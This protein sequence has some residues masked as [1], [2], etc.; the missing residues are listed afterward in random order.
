MRTNSPAFR[1]TER[2]LA[3]GM[4]DNGRL[5]RSDRLAMRLARHT[6]TALARARFLAKTAWYNG[7][8]TPESAVKHVF[9]WDWVSPWQAPAELLEVARLV[10]AQRPK[11]ML[12]IGSAKGGTLFVWCQ[13][14]DPQATVV[15]IDLPGGAF[16][17]GY[18]ADRMPIMFRLK[19][20]YQRLHLLRADSHSSA[21]LH[22]VEAILENNKIQFLFIDG[23]HSYAGVK[24]DFEMYS[25]LVAPGG[26]IG[27]HDIV[28]GPEG[29]GGDVSRFWNEVK[30]R[31]RHREVLA[32]PTHAR[33]GIGLLFV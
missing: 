10:Q 14:A 30:L 3:G 19:Q 5:Q 17:G 24:R 29:T 25:A 13:M 31:F 18:R 16:G 26:I 6:R 21:T 15:S 2:R 9:N 27:F 7:L 20:R 8:F 4:W 32:D 11:T 12:E 33:Y 23:D 28:E 22:R 1:V